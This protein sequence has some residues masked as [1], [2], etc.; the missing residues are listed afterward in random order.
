MTRGVR[1]ASSTLRLSGT[2]FEIG[3][4]EQAFH[5]HVGSTVRLR[6]SSTMRIFSSRFVADVGEDRQLL[7][8][9]ERRDLLDQ[10]ALL[11]AVREFR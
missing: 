6:G 5:Q 11:D 2:R 10:L 7:V 9:D 3:Q 8:V 1:F 4:P